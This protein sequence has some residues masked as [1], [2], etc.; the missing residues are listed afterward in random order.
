M[1]FSVSASPL[2]AVHPPRFHLGG[3]VASR[4][5]S[6]MYRCVHPEASWGG[7]LSTTPAR[8]GILVVGVRIR[9]GGY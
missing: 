3:V 6:D 5:L 1:L 4:G 2:L 8:K 9:E 7:L